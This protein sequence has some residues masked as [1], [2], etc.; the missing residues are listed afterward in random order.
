MPT[1]SS[2]VDGASD[3]QMEATVDNFSPD[4]SLSTTW[5]L[6]TDPTD[7]VDDPGFSLELNDLGHGT[8]LY[9]V[10]NSADCLN[11]PVEE[12]PEVLLEGIGDDGAAQTNNQLLENGKGT[13]ST[14]N[15]EILYEL[16][17]PVVSDAFKKEWENKFGIEHHHQNQEEDSLICFNPLQVEGKTQVALPISTNPSQ[18][19][20]KKRRP[21]LPK[22]F[23]PSG[24]PDILP[25]PVKR[26]KT[27]PNMSGFSSPAVA[28]VLQKNV[29]Q[30]GFDLLEFVTNKELPVNDPTFLAMISDIHPSTSSTTITEEVSRPGPG[31]GKKLMVKK[32]KGRKT[33]AKSNL[34]LNCH[35]YSTNVDENTSGGDMRYRRM[36]DLNNLASKRCRANRKRKFMGLV[37]EE[38]ALK[39]KNA[40]LRM[41]YEHLHD[42]VTR[43]KKE[44][45]EKVSNPAGLGKVMQ[46][47]VPDNEDLDKIFAEKFAAI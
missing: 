7:V 37:E 44:F 2:V 46:I 29:E 20:I 10:V 8:D 16:D 27:T 41:K 17:L 35:S 12:V 36:R 3:A 43:L 21:I 9:E 1:I 40:E 26:E 30:S 5:D 31:P 47:R 34:N 19:K 23:I 32:D 25:P 33:K 4:L 45:I 11:T 42:L 28:S 15:S 22:L 38:E 13:S 14:L 6:L 39:Q 24:Q 18:P